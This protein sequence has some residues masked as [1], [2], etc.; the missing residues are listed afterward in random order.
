MKYILPLAILFVIASC[1][2]KENES[3][4]EPVAGLQQITSKT[5][6]DNEVSAGVSM[7]FY[8]ASW[9][10]ACHA[11]RPAV[12]EVAQDNDLS[13]VFFGEVEY[14]DYPEINE[15][16]NVGAFPT[17]AIYQDGTEVERLTGAGNT[18]AAIKQLIQN[19]L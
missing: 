4:H 6:I 11:Q 13:T 15:A 9:C 1:K 16:Y 19:H 8:H 12:S 5:Q 18:A 3:V 10:E 7:I 17:I 2:K 14:D